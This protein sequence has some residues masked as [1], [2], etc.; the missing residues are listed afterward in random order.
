MSKPLTVQAFADIQ[1]NTQALSSRL[2]Q[3]TGEARD[4]VQAQIEQLKALSPELESLERNLL[5]QRVETE[6]QPGT[7]PNHYQP[8]KAPQVSTEN[9]PEATPNAPTLE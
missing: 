1:G 8:D 2:N 9:L 7:Y 5:D 3:L 4:A 6:A